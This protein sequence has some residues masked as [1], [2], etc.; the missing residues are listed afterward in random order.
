MVQSLLGVGLPQ[1]NPLTEQR[2]Q[3]FEEVFEKGY[4]YAYLYPGFNK[5][6]QAV[7]RVIRTSQDRGI[8]MLIDER[9]Q[10]ST[11]LSLFPYEWQHAKFIN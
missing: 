4:L 8:V 9:Y 11:Y 7:G 2:R 3:H 6:M 1:I 5:V 10:E